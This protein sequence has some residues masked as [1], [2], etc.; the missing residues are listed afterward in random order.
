MGCPEQHTSAPARPTG[1]EG[2]PWACAPEARD[3]GC[4]LDSAENAKEHG[5]LCSVET[6]SLVPRGPRVGY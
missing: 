6:L 2:G 5:V 3:T 1:A 4:L